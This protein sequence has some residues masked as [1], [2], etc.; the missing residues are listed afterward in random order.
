MALT[1][2]IPDETEELVT[3]ASV[4]IDNVDRTT[5]LALRGITA[6]SR[7]TVTVQ[8]VSDLDGTVSLER[9]PYEFYLNGISYDLFSINMELSYN[10]E[11]SYT[12]PHVSFEPENCPGLFENADT[13]TRGIGFTARRL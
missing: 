7:P 2:T 9:G 12:F 10:D 6:T 13:A 8:I 1:F 11:L 5:I 4:T 3:K